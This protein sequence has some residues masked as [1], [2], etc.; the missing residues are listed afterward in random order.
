MTREEAIL[1]A[2]RYLARRLDHD[3]DVIEEATR[4]FALG[5]ILSYQTRRYIATRDF[6][7]RIIGHGPLLLDARDGSLHETGSNP[8]WASYVIDEYVKR[9]ASAPPPPGLNPTH[10]ISSREWFAREQARSRAAIK[11]RR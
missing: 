1:W 2:R 7:D 5:W 8:N 10:G 6:R 11:K 3:L 4:P 9:W